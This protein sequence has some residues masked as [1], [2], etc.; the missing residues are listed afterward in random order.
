MKNIQ[1]ALLTLVPYLLIR[2][3]LT[4]FPEALNQMD[5]NVTETVV[6]LRN[7]IADT[8]FRTM[9]QLANIDFI[10]GLII[11]TILVLVLILKKWKTALIYTSGVI[12]GNVWLNPMLKNFFQRER[13]NEAFRMVSENSYSFPSGHSFASA[14]IYPLTVY[15]MVRHTRLSQHK[16]VAYFLLAVVVLSVGFS[17]IYLG[18]HYLSDVV[19]GFS[20]GFSLNYLTRYFIKKIETPS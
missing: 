10:K 5:Q 4:F 7:V 1:K 8:Y 12:A 15:I 6:Q 18:V 20:L 13:P 17:R 9:T 11:V 16:K 2:I 14:M 19:G 3:L